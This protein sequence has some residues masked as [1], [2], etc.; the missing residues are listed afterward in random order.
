MRKIVATLA[1]ASAAGFLLGPLAA[2][3]TQSKPR[4]AA[5]APV[6][7]DATAH[8][9]QL[10]AVR[11]TPPLASGAKGDAVVRAQILL[12][13]AWFSPGEI[14]GVFSANMRR[15]VAAFQLSRGLPDTGKIDAATW[16][17]LDTGAAVFGTYTVT[18]QDIAGPYL[19]IPQDPMG[20][21]RMPR[22]GYE[23]LTEALAE[24]FHMSPKLLAQLNRGR[25][26]QPG[27]Q[28]V[29]AD[30]QNGLPQLPAAAS[31][32]IDKSD[33]MLYV[34]GQEGRPV[35][36]FPAS[37]GGARDPLQPGRMKITSEVKDPRFTYDPKLIRTAKANET[38]VDLPPGP[39]NPVGVA[40]L[41]LSKKHWGIHG[42]DQPAQMA[43][44]QTNG[45][46]RLTNWDVLRLATLAKPGLA[47]DVQ[48]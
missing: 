12:D 39:N 40:W 11:A 29:A 10:N 9:N 46:V 7:A 3:A 47:V 18:E 35:A 4:P 15:A 48:T 42:T 32:R 38:K 44:A 8:M 37:F 43:R 45:C 21:A 24:R 28:I 27:T 26:I 36:A 5:Q 19:K 17:A 6:P 23:S 20:K 41:G 22:L 30:V 2:Q 1:A 13:R 25:V 33:R 34:L 16:Q 31:I 14:D